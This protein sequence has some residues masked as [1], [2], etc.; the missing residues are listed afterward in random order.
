MLNTAKSVSFY[1]ASA[2]T[3]NTCPVTGEPMP[4]FSKTVQ[5]LMMQTI[6]MHCWERVLG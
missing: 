2:V 3:M 6:H 4:C 1:E 5:Q